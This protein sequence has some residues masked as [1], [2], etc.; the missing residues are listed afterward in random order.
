MPRKIVW[1]TDPASLDEIYQ[2]TG[3]QFAFLSSAKDGLKQCHPWVLC[4]DFIHDAL[5]S[6]ITKTKCS[7][8][9]FKYIA[10]TN[11]V[12]STDKVR[13]LVRRPE[14]KGA[15]D[16]KKAVFHENMKNALKLVNHFEEVADLETRTELSQIK[17]PGGAEVY[18]FRGSSLWVKAPYL[19][20]MFT[21]LIRLGHKNIKF[22]D[23]KDLIKK[24]K[25]Q[26]TK[27]APDN[28][29]RY[30]QS[31]FDKLHIV[32]DNWRD[33]FGDEKAMFNYMKETSMEWTAIP[34][35]DAHKETL[36]KRFSVKGIPTFVILDETG[37]LITKNGRGAIM[38]KGADAFDDWKK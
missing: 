35:G 37:A 8:Y 21:F 19:I 38:S 29:Q 30:L 36:S 9:G 20:S 17:V 7:I 33:L 24:L 25:A 13:M 15:T 22:K 4:R 10:G 1:W 16:K 28:D 2:Q 26:T 32:I 14:L 34:H 31:S 18:L 5:R 6:S 12:V 23:Q 11:P 27:S 3:I